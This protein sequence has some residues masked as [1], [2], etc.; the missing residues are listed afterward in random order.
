MR[1]KAWRSRKGTRWVAVARRR[2]AVAD[3]RNVTAVDERGPDVPVISDGLRRRDDQPKGRVL[4]DRRLT[5][6]HDPCR[7]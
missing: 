5:S 4:L 3:Q 1:Y 2:T 7:L 6:L